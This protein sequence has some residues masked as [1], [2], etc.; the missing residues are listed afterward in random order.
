MKQNKQLAFF[1]TV[2][3][4][5]CIS[6]YQGPI[7]KEK[8]PDQ[9]LLNTNLTGGATIIQNHLNSEMS[10]KITKKINFSQHPSKTYVKNFS[11]AQF[12][13]SKREYKRQMKDRNK[14]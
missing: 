14:M 9:D 2:Q 8:L 1:S 7:L 11:N 5:T 12:N 3:Q 4:L 13:S 6:Y 10:V